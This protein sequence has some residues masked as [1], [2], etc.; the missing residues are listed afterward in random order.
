MMRA[1]SS[2]SVAVVLSLV[3]VAANANL[4]LVTEAEMRAS[5]AAPSLVARAV[6]EKDAPRI[7]IIAPDLHGTVSSPTRVQLKFIATAP[8]APKLDTFR[9]L[10]GA[11]RID[12]TNRLLEYAKLTPEGV[13]LDS[14]NLPSGSHRIFL[15][16]QDSAGRVGT[17][18]LSFTVQ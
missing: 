14:A 13:V 11:F 4:Q 3:S 9:A 5:V 2:L 8:A 6:P 12:I 7:E 15:E 1:T 16:I 18:V 17:Q 10:Y